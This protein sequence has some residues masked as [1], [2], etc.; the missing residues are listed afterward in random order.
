MGLIDCRLFGL[1]EWRATSPL[2]CASDNGLVV[3]PKLNRRS[4]KATTRGERRERGEA[5][6]LGDIT[7]VVFEADHMAVEARVK[8]G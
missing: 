3:E 4:L 8:W 7:P 1:I 6:L 2:A 5:R